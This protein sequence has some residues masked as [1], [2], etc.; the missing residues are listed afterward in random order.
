[1]SIYDKPMTIEELTMEATQYIED[2]KLQIAE[3]LCDATGIDPT[4][5]KI[6]R[7]ICN[8]LCEDN[9]QATKHWLEEHLNESDT[10]L[11]EARLDKIESAFRSAL[12]T[13]VPSRL[14][15]GNE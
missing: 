4:N 11:E 9:L 10:F 15:G 8:S 5:R 7:F 6:G 14:L 13:R 12:F 1:M 3:H 2:I